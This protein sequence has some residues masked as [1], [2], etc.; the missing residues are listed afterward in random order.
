MRRRDLIAAAL[1]LPLAP[2]AQAVSYPAVLPQTLMF[3]RDHGAHPDYRTEWWYLT[4]WLGAPGVPDFGFQ[5]TFF[6]IRPGIAEDNPSAF[7]PRHIVIAHAAIAWPSAGRLLHDSRAARTSFDLAGAATEDIGVHLDRWQMTRE[8]RGLVIDVK[9]H[10]FAL[11]LV[12][13]DEPQRL[14]QGEDGWSQKAPGEEH[15]SHYVSVPQWPLAGSVTVQGKKRSVSGRGW[16]DHEWSSAYMHPDAAGWD[17][18]GI[19]LDDGGAVMLFRMRRKDGSALWYGGTW[20]EASG[21]TRRLGPHDIDWR[22]VREWTSPRTSRRYPVAARIAVGDRTIE[23]RPL[24]DDQELDS[25]ASTGAVYWEG[26]V[27]VVEGGRRIGRGY[28]ELT[29][30]GEQLKM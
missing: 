19:N 12:A 29:G 17:W 23:L 24:M 7:A 30:Y 22:T 4:G 14:L 16:F 10:D 1:G 6:Q 27:T 25:R 8:A 3:P 28:L 2:F 26:A 15:A 11:D 9:S 5:V 13:A 21:E 18:T 20:R